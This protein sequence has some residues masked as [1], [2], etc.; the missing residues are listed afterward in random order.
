MDGAGLEDWV[1]NARMI[2]DSARAVVPPDGN[3]ERIRAERFTPPGFNP[4]ILS[5]MAEMGFLM[6]RVE[7]DHGGLGLGMRELCALSEVLGQG[8]VPEPVLSSI[9]AC[10]LLQEAIPEEVMLGQAV[11]VTA[12]QDRSNALDW[13]GSTRKVHVPGA[14]GAD[15]F[16][17][18]HGD[19][20]SL[21]GAQAQGLR[22]TP[23]GMQDGTEV[24]RLDLPSLPT[25]IRDSDGIAPR[26]LE[27]TLAQSAYLLGV[28]GR[29]LEITL[30]YLRMR[31]QFGKPI[32]SFQALQ[33][34]AT[35]M[36]IQLELSRAGIFAT[37]ARMDA[38]AGN[39]GAA[40]SRCK[41][42]AA[43]LSMM[44][45]REAVQMHGAIGFTDE[46]D[47]GLFVRKAMTEASHFGTARLH[48][49][50]I[51]AQLEEISA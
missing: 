32:G 38:G 40:V 30:E 35:E 46:A 2:V 3:L 39:T 27:A 7:E 17:V 36:K 14:S 4:E 12:W 26:L 19:G 49:A 18:V 47:I 37:A 13:H 9:T 11:I 43:D 6:M 23:H 48:R 10:A 8:L 28:S 41:A 15:L 21:I 1:E 22:L 33:H 20:V 24:C 45:A 25:P 31:S 34:R 50:R 51:A 29:A 44:V 16:A 5:Q 42:R